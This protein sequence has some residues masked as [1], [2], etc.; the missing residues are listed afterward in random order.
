MVAGPVEHFFM[1]EDLKIF[2]YILAGLSSAVLL[3]SLVEFYRRVFRGYAPLEAA[4]NTGGLRAAVDRLVWYGLLQYKV[5]RHRF[6]GIMHA[7]IF[8]G[9]LV[10]FIATIIRA[11]DYYIGGWLLQPPFF[12]VYKLANNIAGILVIVGVTLAA[13]RRWRGLTPGLPRD[14]GYY[15]VLALLAAI[16]TTGFVVEGMVVALYRY[17][18]GFESP[19]YDPVGYLVYLALEGVDRDILVEAYRG[20]WLLHLALAQLGIALI[21]FTNLWHIPAVLANIAFAR[22]GPAVAGLRTY[23][24]LDERI[25]QDK[26]IGVVKLSDTTWK[27]RLDF[28]ACTSC[29][30]CTNSCPAAESGKVLDPRGVVYGLRLKLREGD[31]ESEVLDPENPG[32]GSK[33]GVN[34]EAIWSCLTCGAC[35]NE[36]PVLIHHVDIILD[37][38]RGMMS[39]GSEH[40]PEQVLNVLQNLQYNGNP[41]GQSPLDKEEWFQELGEKLGDEVIAREGEEYEVLYWAGCVTGYDPRIRPVGESILR[42]LRKAG[43]K[44][45]IMPYTGC[46]GE[47]ALRMGEEALFVELMIQFLEELSKYKFKKL[48]VNC[49]HC[50]TTIKHDYRRYR[51]YLEKREDAKHLAEVLDRLEVEHHS[52]TLARLVREGK[53]RAAA[54]DGKPVTYHDPCYLGRWNGVYSE[55]R[56]VLRRGAGL[57]IREMPRNMEKSFCCG[58]GGGQLFYEVKRGRRVSRIRAEEASQTLGGEGVVA[59]A[60]PFCNTMFRA[61]A[62]EFGFEVKDIAEILDKEG[63]GS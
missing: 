44:A 18:E 55:P 35:V 19:L 42:L 40:V 61:E 34:P 38:R 52:V 37:V 32:D 27:Q 43:V 47:P 28:E 30:R 63:S 33:A 3:Y 5:L 26:P 53:L 12:Y 41:L 22:P 48:V 56:E 60:C 31:W 49:P 54:D 4:E 20:L 2:V 15:L 25:E 46:T 10:L 36:C 23:E 51:G 6:P 59:V 24:D 1:V 50:L 14:P 21:P 7:S 9:I 62:E 16:V 39:T 13:Y 11:L 58:G 57:R 45:A 8:Y 29:M 17:G